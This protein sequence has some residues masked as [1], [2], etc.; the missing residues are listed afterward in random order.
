M[1]YNDKRQIPKR[2]EIN[3][4]I[5]TEGRPT[6]GEFDFFFLILRIVSLWSFFFSSINFLY[7]II[8]DLK[9][10]QPNKKYV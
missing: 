1:V 9:Y 5:E 3:K 8:E 6:Y 10:N 2:D 7:L 4:P